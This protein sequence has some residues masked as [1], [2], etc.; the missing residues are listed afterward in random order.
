MACAVW[1]IQVISQAVL[2]GIF[3]V[4]I[5]TWICKAEFNESIYFGEAEE[6]NI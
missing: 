4:F 6:M 3:L 2:N 5:K 1:V